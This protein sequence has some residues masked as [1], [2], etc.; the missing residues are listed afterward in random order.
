MSGHSGEDPMRDA[1]KAADAARAMQTLTRHDTQRLAV[2]GRFGR[3]APDA[4]ALQADD[5]PAR[6]VALSYRID[7]DAVAAAIVERLV[8]G[9]ALRVRDGAE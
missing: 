9:R 3:T 7:P 1:S 5:G 6:I 2:H 4:T 8:A